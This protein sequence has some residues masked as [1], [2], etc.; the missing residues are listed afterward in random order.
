MIITFIIQY[1]TIQ[2]LAVSVPVFTTEEQRSNSL[3]TWS[4]IREQITFALCFPL[5]CIR[6]RTVGFLKGRCGWETYGLAWCYVTLN[7]HHLPGGPGVLSLPASNRIQHHWS[8]VIHGFLISPP[9][10]PLFQLPDM[11]LYK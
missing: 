5:D 7:P 11:Y 10:L 2:L 9:S 4:G 8:S 3:N 1:T 6:R